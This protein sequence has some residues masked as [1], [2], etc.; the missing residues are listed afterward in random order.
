MQTVIC[1]YKT[2]VTTESIHVP[3]QQ[4]QHAPETQPKS[5]KG[6]HQQFDNDN[7]L[8]NKYTE[9]EQTKSK[10]KELELK[11]QVLEDRIPKKYPDV[12]YL[13]Y[14]NRKRILVRYKKEVPFFNSEFS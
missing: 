7:E 2:F 14:K 6:N 12:S 4:Q 9:L 10:L 1:I 3:Q 5:I 8:D 11:I 13:N